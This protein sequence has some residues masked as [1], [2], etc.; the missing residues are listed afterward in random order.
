MVGPGEEDPRSTHCQQGRNAFHPSPHWGGSELGDVE[1]FS[2][3][4]SK[5]SGDTEKTAP[6]FGIKMCLD[7]DSALDDLHT[8][9]QRFS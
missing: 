5:Y 2:G 3:S 8:I 4:S 1:G 9:S 6:S 7:T